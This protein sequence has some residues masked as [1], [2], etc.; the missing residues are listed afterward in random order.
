M[1]RAAIA[2]LNTGMVSSVGVTAAAS[3][4]AIRAKLTN[5]IETR[6]IDSDGE[7]IM[8]H[9]APLVPA[10]GDRAKL[11]K[12]ASLAIAEFLANVPAND[13]SAIPLILCIA[14]RAR[15]GR[16]QGIDDDLLSDIQQELGFEFSQDSV[17]LPH[18]RVAGGAALVHARRLLHE[19]RAPFVIIAATDTLLT[20]PTL[21]A[22][23]RQGRLLGPKNSNGFIPGEGAAALL[24]GPA[25]TT[26]GLIIAGLGFATEP[27]SIDSEQPLRAEGMARAIKAAAKEAGCDI[28]DLSFRISDLSGEQ[29]YFKEASLALSR[30]LRV[31]KEKFD[32]WHPAECIGE[33]G[34]VGGVAPLVVALAACMKGYAPGPNILC[35]ASADSGERAATI[36]QYWAG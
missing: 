34:A 28:H 6:F 15:P 5:P 31:R 23:E 4:A 11:A 20:W 13:L 22:Y 26:G 8:A 36:L 25:P 18:G 3:C 16:L 21:Q 2:I 14:E 7:W 30:T 19:N 24:I 29:Y 35:Q 10:C 27:A 1:S 33:C 17:I 9:S 12:M 32:I